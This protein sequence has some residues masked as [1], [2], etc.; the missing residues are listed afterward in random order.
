M[1]V[2]KKE[3]QLTWPIFYEVAPCIVTTMVT[4]D[5]H[6]NEIINDEIIDDDLLT[7]KWEIN[8]LL[9]FS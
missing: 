2:N 3:V 4:D 5:I 8:F 7:F 1:F 9:W 6:G